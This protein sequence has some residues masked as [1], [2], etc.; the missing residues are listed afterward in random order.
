MGYYGRQILC[1]EPSVVSDEKTGLTRITYNV[2]GLR[3]S[4][5]ISVVTGFSKKIIDEMT[6]N[7]VAVRVILII[8]GT[9]LYI[10]LEFFIRKKN[11]LIQ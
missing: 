6:I 2:Y 9:F 10:L 1:D 11:K 7:Q 3:E 4:E 5:G 8:A